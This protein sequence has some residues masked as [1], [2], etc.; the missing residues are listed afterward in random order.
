MNRSAPLPFVARWSVDLIPEAETDQIGRAGFV[1]KLDRL[2]HVLDGRLGLECAARGHEAINQ[3][4]E[5]SGEAH[6][7]NG[8]WDCHEFAI[9]KA[10]IDK[11]RLYFTVD[12]RRSVKSGS[13]FIHANLGGGHGVGSDGLYPRTSLVLALSI[14]ISDDLFREEHFECGFLESRALGKA[15][16]RLGNRPMPA[17]DL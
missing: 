9:L 2:D 5:Q 15:E 10:K 17:E 1:I 3:D 11:S 8:P 13:Y 7:V 12:N 16:R 4:E 6:V 14:L